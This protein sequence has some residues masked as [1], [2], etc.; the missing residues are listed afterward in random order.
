MAASRTRAQPD[1]AGLSG[2]VA[3]TLA[4][5]G[6]TSGSSLCVALSGGVDSVVLLH[7]LAELRR[8]QSFGLTAAHVHHGLSPRADH[9]REFCADLCFR[10][11]VPMQAFQ[12]SVERHH[13][14]GL[15]GAARRARHA[16]LAGVSADWLVFG[17]HRDDQAETVLFRLLRGAGVRG[18]AAMSMIDPGNPGRL[19]PLI[20]SR[21]AEIDAYARAEG[22][23][24]VEDESNADRRHARNR[25]RHDVMPAIEAGFPSGV[26]MLARCA[27]NFG[28]ADALL[29]ELAELD[30][31]VCGG[32]ERFAL[33][34]ALGLSDARL[35]NLL[36]WRLQAIGAEAPPRA[37][38]IE[39]VRQLRS[40]NVSS[41]QFPLGNF[42][43][44][45]HR[46]EL[47]FEPAPGSLPVE[48]LWSGERALPWADGRVEFVRGEGV[49]L[50]EALLE[51]AAQVLLARRG[52]G[53]RMSTAPGRP[54][55]S[56]K[57]LCQEAGVPAWRREYLPV[58][59][60]DGVPVWIDGIGVAPQAQ[61][62]PGK[63]GVL[64]RWVRI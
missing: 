57:N 17:H 28:E 11:D 42:A 51:S 20:D 46:G 8:S 48:R 45:V 55:H 63:P 30:A 27:T 13:P 56:F 60:V 62:E 23:E 21:R 33:D 4:V 40:I 26:D 34:A 2:R 3:A 5:A 54:R 19:R 25:L 10:L 59:R 16:A 7:L 43:C 6:I 58:L 64:P 22:L 61:C 50:S 14:D 12:V 37:R 35:R 15:E 38:L 18:A 47:W 53:L 52:E 9:W 24:W 39:A 44:C 1:G 31:A 49:G 32:P 41:L 36:R 29:G